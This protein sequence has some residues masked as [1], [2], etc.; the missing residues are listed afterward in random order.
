MLSRFKHF[1]LTANFN[2]LFNIPVQSILLQFNIVSLLF[3]TDLQYG[4]LV[5]F[6]VFSEPSLL[7]IKGSF[8]AGIIS[9]ALYTITLSPILI[10]L[11]A[12]LFSD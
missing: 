7:N 8:I 9:P 2:L 10:S 1:L 6:I 5:I 11:L 4:H 3:K 12:K